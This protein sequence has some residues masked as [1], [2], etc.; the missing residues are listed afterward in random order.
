MLLYD[1][2][3]DA[4]IS[5]TGTQARGLDTRGRCLAGGG[6]AGSGASLRGHGAG[7]S[8]PLAGPRL[9]A[10]ADRAR[11]WLHAGAGDGDLPFRAAELLIPG[12][13][14]P[15]E[16]DPVELQEQLLRFGV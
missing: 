7:Q 8:L 5:G 1:L 14:R 2:E 16:V 12:V 10:A 15:A 9:S 4:S 6:P 13:Q 11:A 3:R